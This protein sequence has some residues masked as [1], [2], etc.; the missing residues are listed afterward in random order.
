MSKALKLGHPIVLGPEVPVVDVLAFGPGPNTQLLSEVASKHRKLTVTDGGTN[1]Y[2]EGKDYVIDRDDKRRPESITSVANSSLD[3]AGAATV[4]FTAAYVT[5]DGDTHA[6]RTT[7]PEVRITIDGTAGGCTV[8]PQG[9]ADGVAWYSMGA[10]FVVAPGQ[11]RTRMI[12]EP[13]T[14]VRAQLSAVA[15]INKVT[16]QDN[17]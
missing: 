11:T 15:G 6:H 12:E 9:S 8:Q 3:V 10:S 14:Y 17:S 2:Y 5:L 13:N 4:T 1:L 16:V 7:A